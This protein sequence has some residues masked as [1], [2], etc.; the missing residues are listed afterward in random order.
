[1]LIVLQAP[2]CAQNS[3]S[4]LWKGLYAIRKTK[5][6][7][8]DIIKRKTASAFSRKSK[9]DFWKGIKAIKKQLS[10]NTSS[11]PVIDG[12]TSD[13]E[14]CDVFQSNFS[15]LLNSHVNNVE[16][17]DTLIPDLMES[18]SS[19]DLAS[20]SIPSETVMHCLG[21]LS[22]H[23][24][25]NSPLAYNHLIAASPVLSTVEPRLTTTPEEQPVAL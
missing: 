10:G 8:L 15:N 23:K 6:R 4:I 22:P 11:C 17:P 20:I 9:A 24:S 2:Y 21:K 1:M 5:R 13:V 12:L 16:D 25:D 14:I 3:A 18:L 19:D 7:R